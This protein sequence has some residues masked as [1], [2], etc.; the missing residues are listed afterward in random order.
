MGH[1]RSLLSSTARA[2]HKIDGFST[3]YDAALNSKS[4][5]NFDGCKWEVHLY[6]WQSDGFVNHVVLKIIFLGNNYLGIKWTAN[7]SC[8]LMDPTGSRPPS[9]EK[10]SAP[11]SFAYNGSEATF[12]FMRLDEVYQ[13]GYYLRNDDSLIIEC[14]INVCKDADAMAIP[15]PSSNLPQHL[16]ELLES[17]VGS[18]VTFTVAGESFAAHKKYVLAARSSVFMAELFGEMHEKSSRRIKIRE[19]EP[20]VFR[21]MLRFIYTDA[22]PELDKKMDAATA[23]LA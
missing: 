12:W 7:L 2:V 14:V 4:T 18:D 15:V 20:S 23:T 10:I 21:A 11:A 6:P 22:V 16:G 8:R 5:W 1:S 19:M 17:Q 9:E 13:S 3:G